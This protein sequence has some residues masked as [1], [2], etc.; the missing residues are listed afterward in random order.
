MVSKLLFQIPLGAAHVSRERLETTGL[1]RYTGYRTHSSPEGKSLLS[2][3]IC[4]LRIVKLMFS[5]IQQYPMEN[6]L[7]ARPF[8]DSKI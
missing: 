4:C 8:E 5:F 2:S 7:G 1:S 6:L 3:Q